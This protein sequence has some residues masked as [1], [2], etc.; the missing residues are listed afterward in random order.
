MKQEWATKTFRIYCRLT[1]W[2][3]DCV[4][5]LTFRLYLA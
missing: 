3:S 2:D 4:Y 1:T 5:L